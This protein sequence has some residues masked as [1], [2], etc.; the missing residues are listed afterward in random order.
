MGLAAIGIGI[1]SF[2]GVQLNDLFLLLAAA[3]P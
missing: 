3:A 2:F 1:I